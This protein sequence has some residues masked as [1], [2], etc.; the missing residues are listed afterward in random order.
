MEFEDRLQKAIARGEKA[1]EAQEREAAGRALTE[2]EFKRLHANLRM[3]LADHIE[4]CLQR[5]PDY[6]PGFH[7]DSIVGE[8]GWGA[9]CSRDDVNLGDGGRRSLYSRLEIVVRPYSPAHIVEV[10]AKGTIRNREVF[11][12]SSYQKLAQSDA[13]PLR[14]SVDLWVLEY[15]EHYAA[16]K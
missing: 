15:A 1:R 11:N 8:K 12:R 16:A 3:E 9:A 7:V 5:L 10:T 6:F 13:Q 4:K 14:D 2:E